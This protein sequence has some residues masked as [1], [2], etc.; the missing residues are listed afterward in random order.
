MQ[1]LTALSINTK[2]FCMI[3]LHKHLMYFFTLEYN[4]FWF[5]SIK[6]QCSIQRYNFLVYNHSSP[7]ELTL[8][9]SSVCNYWKN[10]HFKLYVI[11]VDDSHWG[12]PISHEKL[13]KNWAT[14]NDILLP[15][16]QLR[17]WCCCWRPWGSRAPTGRSSR[18]PCK[19]NALTSQ[20]IRK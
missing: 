14:K 4:L 15:N 9:T 7:I 8:V 10:I 5:F 3:R 18:C 12:N 20:D 1:R 13:L 6:V 16:D 19:Y 2:I 11:S 17:W